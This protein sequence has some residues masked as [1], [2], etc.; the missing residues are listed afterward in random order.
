LKCWPRGM[1][2]MIWKGAD[3]VEIDFAQKYDV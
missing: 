3:C 1:G 2:C